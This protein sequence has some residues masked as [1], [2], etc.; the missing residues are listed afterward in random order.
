MIVT[1]NLPPATSA[2]AIIG[3]IYATI[4]GLKKIPRLTQY[5]T[6]WWAVGLN[7][8]LAVCGELI[9]VP[10]DQL[11]TVNTLL[12]LITTILGAAGVHGTVKS[13]SPPTVLA[14]VPPSTQVKEVPA[15]LEP[16]NPAAVVADK[17]EVKNG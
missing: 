5:L 3:A 13:M 10:A 12:L 2:L 11:Y 9:V 7:A 15:T 16:V 1:I 17:G 6:G 8:A 14:T 4:Q